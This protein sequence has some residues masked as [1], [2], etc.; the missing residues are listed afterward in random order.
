[1]RIVRLSEPAEAVRRR[2]LG[3]FASVAE[4][5]LADMRI[6]RSPADYDPRMTAY[7]RTYLDHVFGRQAADTGLSGGPR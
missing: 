4:P 2:I 5:E 6:V 1:V 3:N 7:V